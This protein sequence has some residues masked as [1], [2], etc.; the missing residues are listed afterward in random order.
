MNKT[1]PMILKVDLER[2]GAAEIRGV[3]LEGLAW[4]GARSVDLGRRG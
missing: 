4:W 2:L 3:D 1:I